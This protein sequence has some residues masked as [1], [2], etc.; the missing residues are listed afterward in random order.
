MGSETVSFEVRNRIADLDELHRKVETFA[1]TCGMPMKCTFEVSLVLEELFNNIISYGFDGNGEHPIRFTLSIDDNL[2]TMRIEDTGAPFN[3]VKATDP[4]V[5]CPL[6]DR[7]IGGLGVHLVKKLS[8][9][10]TYE[11]TGTK[12]ILTIVKTV[13]PDG[14]GCSNLIDG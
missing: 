8:N 6:M 14:C 12:N 10:M 11:R 2:L 13:D 1:E 3:P 7:E 4:D 9:R 5:K